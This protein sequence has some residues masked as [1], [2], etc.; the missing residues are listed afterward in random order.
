VIGDVPQVIVIVICLNLT[1]ATF[2]FVFVEKLGSP[3][4]DD[5][6]QKQYQS[7]TEY[8]FLHA[9]ESISAL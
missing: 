6:L 9:Y 4:S 8:E 1:T 7:G 2:S 5:E 3:F